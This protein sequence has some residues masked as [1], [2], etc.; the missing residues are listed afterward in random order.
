ML[1]SLNKFFLICCELFIII[2]TSLY[3]LRHFEDTRDKYDQDLV[4]IKR[5]Y[6]LLN[7]LIKRTN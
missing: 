2:K 1:S 6:T 7:K 3:F 5:H 4:H